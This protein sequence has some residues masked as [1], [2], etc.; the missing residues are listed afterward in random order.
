M[1]KEIPMISLIGG[2]ESFSLEEAVALMN[3][4]VV[5]AEHMS[6]SPSIEHMGYIA[7]VVS[8]ND[9]I[10]ILVKFSDELMQINKAGFEDLLDV[11]DD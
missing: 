2:R 4:H 3:L 5:R 10:E 8:L 7:G 1:K 9:E 11:V 6:A